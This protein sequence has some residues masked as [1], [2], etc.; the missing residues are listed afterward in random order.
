MESSFDLSALVKTYQKEVWMYLR[1][2]GCDPASAD[3]L[4]QETFL[5]V[6]RR[7]FDDY[8]PKA[9]AAYLRRVA[10]NRFLMAIRH[11]KS[12]PSHSSLDAVDPAFEKNDSSQLSY[13]DA[14]RDCMQKLPERM[15]QVMTARYQRGL[16]SREIGEELGLK[17]DHVNTIS[18]RAK[19]SLK[20]C[21][22]KTLDGD[23]GPQ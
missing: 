13:L 10:K 4:T 5:E 3:D 20:D 2:L 15:R 23:G 1:V 14:L 18:Y 12:R 9:T 17:E 6:M 22:K 8:N 21:V 16:K 7:P 11:A 19:D